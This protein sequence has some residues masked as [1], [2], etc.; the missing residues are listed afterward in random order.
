LTWTSEKVFGS[1]ESID[2]A[3]S[4]Y[5]YTPTPKRMF[6]LAM[7]LRSGISIEKI[8]AITGIDPWFLYKIQ[9][10]VDA[11]YDLQASQDLSTSR[12]WELKQMGMSDKRIGVLTGKTG[13]EIRKLRKDLDV[14]PSVFQIDTLAAEFP[15]DTNYLYMTYNGHHND[16]EPICDE[17]VVILGSGPYRIGSSVEFDWTSVSTVEALKRSRQTTIRRTVSTLKN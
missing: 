2:D 5:L 10:I 3:I 17:G 15:S 7:A 16:V 12:L 4:K 14:V 6:A 8:Y 11:E 9:R 13:L 1:T